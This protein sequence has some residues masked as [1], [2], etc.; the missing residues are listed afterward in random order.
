MTLGEVRGGNAALFTVG[1]VHRRIRLITGCI[2][3][4]YVATHFIDH[5]TGNISLAAMEAVLRVQKWIWQGAIGTLL[6]YSALTIHG[7]LGIWSLYARRYTGWSP[8]EVVQLM[9]GLGIPPLLANHVAVTRIALATYGLDKAYSQELTTLW[10]LWPALGIIQV[11]VLIVAWTHAC[12]GLHLAFR[13]QRWYRRVQ[14]GLL[15]AAIL[16]PMLALLGFVQGSREVGRHLGDPAWRA[17]HLSAAQTGTSEQV[18]FL[19][20]MRNVFLVCYGGLLLVV[21]LARGLRR[22]HEVRVRSIGISYPDGRIARVPVGLSVLDASLMLGVRHA[23]MCGG[24]GRCSTCRVRVVPAGAGEAPA[25]TAEQAVL[26]RIGVDALSTRLACQF[27]PRRDIGVMPLVP[28][29]AAGDF[30]VGGTHDLAGE[31]RFV[32][33]MFVD[34]RNSTALIK[35]RL[36]YDAVFVVRRFIETAAGAVVDVGGVP[37]QFFGDGMLALFGLRVPPARGC[38]QA[39][40]AVAGLARAMRELNA[41]FEGELAQPLRFGIGVHCGPAVVGEIGFQRHTT[42]TALGEVVHVTARLQE[43]SRDLGCDAV[44][45]DEVVARAKLRFPGVRRSS[46]TVRGHGTPIAAHLLTA[47]E[48]VS[49]R[50]G[51]VRVGQRRE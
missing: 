51:R 25:S 20:H 30:V 3:F 39:I 38:F 44:I 13:L 17:A 11:S 15:I 23:S 46:I 16:L 28:P 27:R 34:M 48:L 45:S 26:G 32:V 10:F 7:F 42:F 40:S 35:E 47:P 14:S 18:D 43:A 29:D 22:I 12:I 41:G 19:F 50:L 4:S 9:F 33:A 6:L 24:R 5:S 1:P 31:E 37:N 2:L 36:P 49:S 21:V 8:P